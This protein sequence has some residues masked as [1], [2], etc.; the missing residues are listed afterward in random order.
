MEAGRRTSTLSWRQPDLY[1]LELNEILPDHVQG[2]S[3]EFK[4][5]VGEG[6]YYC[7]RDKTGK[8]VRAT[9]WIATSLASHVGIAVPDFAPI[10]NPFADEIL[11]G[12]K[13]SWGTADMFETQTFLMTGIVDKAVGDPYPW[14]SPYLSRLFVYDM[15]VANDDR[16]T[17]NFLLVKDG[18]AKRLFAFDF[19]SANLRDW[20][21]CNFP[22]ASSQT[23][24]VGR[25]LR[26]VRPFDRASANEMLDWLEGVAPT[27]IERIMAGMPDEWMTA[28]ERENVSDQWMSGAVRT[29]LHALRSGINDG[30]LL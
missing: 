16:Q 10:Y 12:S 17:S 8:P 25:V 15:F 9:E 27:T 29:R 24:S 2:G 18:A 23:M 3:I 22:V 26:S 1:P 21:T 14:V 28:G 7:K 4:A 11:F 5:E 6:R 20:S 30:S 13:E 19:A